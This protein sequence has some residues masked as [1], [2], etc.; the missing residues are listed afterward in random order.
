VVGGQLIHIKSGEKGSIRHS[1]C[2]AQFSEDQ[3]YQASKTSCQDVTHEH[4]TFASSV[5]PIQTL[6]GQYQCP[7]I[8]I[9]PVKP[10]TGA[11]YPK[12]TCAKRHSR[13][14]LFKG[15][16]LG[17]EIPCTRLHS[18]VLRVCRQVYEEGTSVL[19]ST[20]TFSFNDA[21]SFEDFVIATSNFIQKTR[22]VKLHFRST[23]TPETTAGWRRALRSSV[24]DNLPGV[25]TL[26][27]CFDHD[28]TLTG[29][30]PHFFDTPVFDN[31]TDHPFSWL[32]VLPI[33]HATVV[34]TDNGHL[35]PDC[36]GRRW[37]TE[38]MRATA[39]SLQR[40][41]LHPTEEEYLKAKEEAYEAGQ[42]SQT[43]LEFRTWR[44]RRRCLWPKV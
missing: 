36:A 2:V 5:Y 40:K 8:L 14:A 3:A 31:R 37:T 33:Q 9:D 18:S 32:L 15:S 22:L 44:L 21:R 12:D 34:F 20:N 6:E 29:F 38:Q 41:L 4:G 24:I 7:S 26:H 43:L 42:V 13:C 28:V 23:I 11:E 30:P 27:I 10:L 17:Q 35:I 25:R 19:W 39:D 1:I 16:V